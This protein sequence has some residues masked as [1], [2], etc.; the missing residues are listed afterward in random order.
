MTTTSSSSSSQNNHGRRSTYSFQKQEK[1]TP[2]TTEGKKKKKTMTNSIAKYATAILRGGSESKRVDA[3]LS[4][5]VSKIVSGNAVYIEGFHCEEDDFQTLEQLAED[6]DNTSRYLGSTSKR[7]EEEEEEEEEE[8]VGGGFEGGVVNWS[9]HLKQENPEFSETFRT[10]VERMASYFD[11]D[12]YATRL[13]FYRDGSDWKPYHHDSHAF[14]ANGRKEDFTMGASF[15]AQRALSFLHEPS[16]SSFEFPQKNGDVFAFSSE[17]NAAMQ[18]GVP[19]LSGHEQF[20]ANPRF[21]VIAW[22]RRRSLNPRNSAASEEGDSGGG[23]GSRSNNQIIGVDETR[24]PWHSNSNN[25]EN[26]GGYEGASCNSS[27]SSNNNNNIN[28]KNDNSNNERV[29]SNDEVSQLVRE[30]VKR[31]RNETR[32]TSNA[33][34]AHLRDK[35]GINDSD[36]IRVKKRARKYQRGEISVK[37]FVQFALGG[38][39]RV[40][41]DVLKN[42]CSY[43]PNEQKKV[44]LTNELENYSDALPFLS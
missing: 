7:K 9:K 30:F 2:R 34:V 31:K 41:V 23:G 26:E 10:V 36:I 22:G 42:L 32:K 40:S 17:V 8:D 44:E 18:H 5:T 33:L 25:K 24:M 19:R 16:A 1:D 20:V 37:E 43:L 3:G 4:E 39:G 38:G 13:N 12:V 11:V 27:S 35:V 14:G 28:N 6:L 29:M 15:G 21:S